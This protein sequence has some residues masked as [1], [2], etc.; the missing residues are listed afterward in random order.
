MSEAAS[1]GVIGYGLYAI[2]IGLCATVAGVMLG[3][4]ICELAYSA[5]LL[6]VDANI[7]D[8]MALTVTGFGM[9]GGLLGLIAGLAFGWRVISDKGR[10]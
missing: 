10:G 8:D 5:G 6:K 3:V 4:L 2:A 1:M 9:G 7:D